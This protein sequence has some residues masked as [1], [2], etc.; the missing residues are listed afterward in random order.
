MARSDY[1]RGIAPIRTASELADLLPVPVFLLVKGYA[2]AVFPGTDRSNPAVRVGI[3]GVEP[4]PDVIPTLSNSLPVWIHWTQWKNVVVPVVA[5]LRISWWAG[6]NP[7]TGD[8]LTLASDVLIPQS[9]GQVQYAAGTLVGTSASS[10]EPTTGLYQYEVEAY[11]T[12]I[13]GIIQARATAQGY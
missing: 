11:L 10:T 12:E 8:N 5:D 13:S 6:V 2:K 7:G 3:M 1:R 9:G 4:V